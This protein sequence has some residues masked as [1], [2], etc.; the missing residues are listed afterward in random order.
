MSDKQYYY[1]KLMD[2]V[3]KGDQWTIGGETMWFPCT[4]SI[5]STYGAY[6]ERVRNPTYRVRRLIKKTPKGNTPR[7][8]VIN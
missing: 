3:K 2:V 6:R 7:C 1:L 8:L 5:G 4:S